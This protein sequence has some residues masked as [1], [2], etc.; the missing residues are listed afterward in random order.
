M[1]TDPCKV[2]SEDLFRDGS[3]DTGVQFCS[4]SVDS[5]VQTKVEMKEVGVQVNLPLLT[6]EDL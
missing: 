4:S 3:R 5:E 6:A 2:Y 1:R